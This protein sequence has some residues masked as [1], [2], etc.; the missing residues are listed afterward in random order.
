LTLLD[1]LEPAGLHW[2]GNCNELNAGYAAY[3]YPRVKGIGAL[4]TTFGVGK[5]SAIDAIAGAYA[6]KT[7][8]VHIVGTLS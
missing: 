2:A 1:Y 3:G 4:I 5:L 6:E 7:P 8:V